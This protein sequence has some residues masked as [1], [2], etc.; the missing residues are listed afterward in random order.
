MVRL[1]PARVRAVAAIVLSVLIAGCGQSTSS[2]TGKNQSGTTQSGSQAG[3]SRKPR[4]AVIMKSLAN[5]FFSTMAEG[6]RQHQE[7]A[8]ERYELLVRGIKDE[9]DLSQQVALVE[10]M[11]SQQVDAIVIAP[12]DSK[13]LV[14]V[15]KRARAAG[16]V[17]VNIDNQLD[18]EVL[19]QAGIA[20]PFVGP[21]NRAG[22]RKVGEFLAQHLKPGDQVGVLEGIRTAFNAQQRRLGFDDAMRSAQIEIVDSQSAQW[23]VE[24][25]NTVAAGMISEHPNIKGLLCSN[26]NMAL[27]ALAATK[28]AG[29]SGEIAIV[30]FDNI[31]AIREAI[32]VGT[33]LA[34]ADQHGDQL[35]VYGIEFALQIIDGQSAPANQET[36]VDLITRESGQ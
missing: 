24:V 2:Q 36:P 7:A 30:G 35:A 33:I 10:E 11:I 21:D 13:A 3:A 1:M 28:A 4:V 18:Q 26:D 8:P 27:G 32:Q 20:I 12:A 34:T 29:R 14:G 5:E 17:V 23:E 31:S 22:A 6:A 25:A 16:V 9:R 15:L 19:Q